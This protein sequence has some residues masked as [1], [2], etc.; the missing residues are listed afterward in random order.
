MRF[1]PR[2]SSLTQQQ[3]QQQQ[4]AGISSVFFGAR[5]CLIESAILLIARQ[6]T[7]N[8]FRARVSPPFLW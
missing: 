3:Q 1:G 5:P 2:A 8:H 7:S 6:V 4:D